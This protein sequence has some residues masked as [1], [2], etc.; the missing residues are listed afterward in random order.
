[1]RYYL[2]TLF[3]SLSLAVFA[4]EE[5]VIIKSSGQESWTISSIK[6]FTFDG[7]GVKL[8][9]N[10]NTSVYYEK[11]T[12]NM[13]K[14]NSTISSVN[15]L[16]KATQSISIADNYIIVEGNTEDIKV[17]SL[18]GAVVA[19]G[20]CSKLDISHLENGTYIVQSG[21]LISKIVKQ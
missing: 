15:N 2:I 10:D 13:I 17:F 12:L 21:S 5:V 11:G 3:L 18:S 7:N 19:Q 20:K 4:S 6:D 1:M 8:S 16:N 14:F 9:F